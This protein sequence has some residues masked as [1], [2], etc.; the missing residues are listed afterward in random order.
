MRF[1]FLGLFLGIAACSSPAGPA[2]PAQQGKTEAKSPQPNASAIAS[3]APAVSS[4]VAPSLPRQCP[5]CTGTTPICSHGVCVGITDL[6]KDPSS[7]AFLSNGSARYIG[8][9]GFS[10]E[11]SQD[12]KEVVGG[13]S[14][15]CVLSRA[16]KVVCRAPNQAFTEVTQLEGA[17]HLTMASN[18]VC[19]S[20][21]NGDILCIA[22]DA[23]LRKISDVVIV[24]RQLS[25]SVVQFEHSEGH[26]CARLENGNVLCWGQNGYAQC[27]TKKYVVLDSNALYVLQAELAEGVS[28]AIDVALTN[29]S[30]CA[31][32]GDGG[33][34]CWG[35]LIG[36]ELNDRGATD[37]MLAQSMTAADQRALEA[38]PRANFYKSTYRK[39]QKIPGLK[40]IVKIAFALN[41][42]WAVRK[43]G[44][45]AWVAENDIGSKRPKIEVFQ[46]A[47]DVVRFAA[48]WD[49]ACVLTSQHELFCWREKDYGS[50]D[51]SP[52]EVQK[53][54]F[55]WEP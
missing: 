38:T 18:N 8:S 9:T 26:A 21:T 46:G 11:L 13:S 34:L 50:K 41:R 42:L 20:R 53:I 49:R 12:G 44:T 28:N 32:T 36:N 5:P 16:G 2:N 15:T 55:E 10:S 30:S 43:D 17:T 6:G 48:N 24:A 51:P 33:V 23:G 40:D 1:S 37:R 35:Q 3:A 7:L 14:S 19:A 45:I 52:F 31:V 4:S 27:G 47:S 29:M 22:A 25:S 54:G 39:P